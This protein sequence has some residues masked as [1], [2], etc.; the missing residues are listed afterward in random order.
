VAIL[1]R[2]APARSAGFAPRRNAADIR[3]Y[4]MSYRRNCAT[5]LFFGH[6]RRSGTPSVR[7]S[8]RFLVPLLLALTASAYAAMTPDE[9]RDRMRLMRSVV[10]EFNVYRWACRMLFDAAAMRQRNRFR[11]RSLVAGRV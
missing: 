3:V 4:P 1:A 2:S 10:R 8:L 6:R 7:L 9:Q 5:H 11:A